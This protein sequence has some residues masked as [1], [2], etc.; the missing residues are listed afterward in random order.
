[1]LIFGLK[2]KNCVDIKIR[3]NYCQKREIIFGRIQHKS[4]FFLIFQKTTRCYKTLNLVVGSKK[5][6]RS[7][8]REIRDLRCLKFE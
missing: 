8:A 1:V 5:K 6:K 4:F 7:E 3:E 2:L